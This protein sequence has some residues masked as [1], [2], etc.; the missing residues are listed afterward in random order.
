MIDRS[1]NFLAGHRIIRGTIQF[2][3]NASEFAV[4]RANPAPQNG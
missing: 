1:G 4:L 2:K 3:R